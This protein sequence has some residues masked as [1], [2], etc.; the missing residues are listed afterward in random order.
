MWILVQVNI[1]E[2]YRSYD[3]TLSNFCLI[4]WGVILFSCLTRTQVAE[5]RFKRNSKEKFQEKFL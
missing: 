4:I 3:I 2:T 5:T 1:H